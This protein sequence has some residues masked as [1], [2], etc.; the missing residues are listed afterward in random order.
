MPPSP[1]PL[2]RRQPIT[3][4]CHVCRYST[5]AEYPGAKYLRGRPVSMS[6]PTTTNRTRNRWPKRFLFDI[7]SRQIS[8]NRHR[9]DHPILSGN[10]LINQPAT[11]HKIL[12]SPRSNI[13]IKKFYKL[14]LISN[15]CLHF[16]FHHLIFWSD[17]SS[18]LDVD[19]HGSMEIHA[20][21]FSTH[22]DEVGNS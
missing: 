3:Q 1:A 10:Q 19:I 12:G 13:A 21:S 7:F 15:S 17:T 16:H 5:L 18:G 9:S 14:E 2:R 4:S 6:L 8:R 20:V 22:G 11:H